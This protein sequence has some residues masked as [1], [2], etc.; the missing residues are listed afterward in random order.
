VVRRLIKYRENFTIIIF[1]GGTEISEE[2][3]VSIF[4]VLIN[5]DWAPSPLSPPL[6]NDYLPCNST[7]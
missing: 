4:R 6:D 7:A 3:V 1:I 2:C 5:V